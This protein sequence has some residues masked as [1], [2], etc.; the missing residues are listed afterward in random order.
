MGEGSCGGE[1]A[2]AWRKQEVDK[3]GNEY[4]G[5]ND[6]RNRESGR[7]LERDILG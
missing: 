1:N 4:V 2:K 6:F 7:R 3:T 5:K